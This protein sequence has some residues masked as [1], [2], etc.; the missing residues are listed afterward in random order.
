MVEQKNH[1]NGEF[2]GNGSNFSDSIAAQSS[3]SKNPIESFVKYVVSQKPILNC[4]EKNV[5]REELHSELSVF[6]F[7]YVAKNAIFK[8]ISNEHRKPSLSL[9]LEKPLKNNQS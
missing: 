6:R 4:R 9:K 7:K 1:I 5:L 3:S 8:A 2:F